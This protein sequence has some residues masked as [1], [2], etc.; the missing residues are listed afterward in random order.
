MLETF[1]IIWKQQIYYSSAFYLNRLENIAIQKF[2]SSK[3]FFVNYDEMISARRADIQELKLCQ[4]EWFKYINQPIPEDFFKTDVLA[5]IAKDED[6]YKLLK[7]RTIELFETPIESDEK[8]KTQDIGYWGESLVH[9][10]ECTRLKVNGREDLIHLIK[11]IPTC[12]ALGYDIK[13]VE[14][15]ETTRLIEVKTTISSKPINFNKFHLTP[16]EWMA[17]ESFKERYHVYRLYFSKHY[18][19]LYVL[20]NPVGLYKN[21]TEKWG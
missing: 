9:G 6:N 4:S 7:K 19:K 12:L 21:D 14:T 1:W 17:A 18:K 2:C 3:D 8:I 10:H 20:S 11:R 5:L 15:D 16:N 13:S